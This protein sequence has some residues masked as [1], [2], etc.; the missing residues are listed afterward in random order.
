MDGSISDHTAR[1]PERVWGGG[2]LG[3]GPGARKCA[4]AALVPQYCWRQCCW[5]GRAARTDDAALSQ[6]ALSSKINSRSEWAG[7]IHAVD[8]HDEAAAGA[9]HGVA[10]VAGADGGDDVARS[11]LQAGAQIDAAGIGRNAEACR[12]EGGGVAV[13]AL[14]GRQVGVGAQIRVGRLIVR[15]ILRGRRGIAV[16]MVNELRLTTSEANA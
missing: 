4:A 15:S 9:A 1:M 6:A 2:L 10:G 8:G 5:G 7:D 16:E 11:G 3:G 14:G 13:E 12:R